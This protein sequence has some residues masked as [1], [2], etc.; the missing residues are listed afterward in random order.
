MANEKFKFI[1]CDKNQLHVKSEEV[2]PEEVA[3]LS[4]ALKG[5][6]ILCKNKA[7]GLSAIQL[8]IPKQACI[9]KFDNEKLLIFN[10]VITKVGGEEVKHT[11]GCLSIPFKKFMITRNSEVSV[12]YRDKNWN[13]VSAVFYGKSAFA[14][15]HE[16][17][18][19]N[20]IILSDIGEEVQ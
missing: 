14:V 17:D 9:I 5:H 10:P 7:V 18:H 12:E 6:L 11:E 20:G 2:K 1:T 8:G 15:Q 3:K 16:I 13:I 19:M 4:N